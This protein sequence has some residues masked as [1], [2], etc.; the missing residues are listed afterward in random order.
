MCTPD[1]NRIGAL[2]ARWRRL[3]LSTLP[4]ALFL[5]AGCA[6][7]KARGLPEVEAPRKVEEVGQPKAEE[8]PK[9]ESPPQGQEA[10]TVRK[11]APPIEQEP[12]SFNDPPREYVTRE[13]GKWIVLVEKELVDEEP[14]LAERALAR[15]E[16]LLG[17]AFEAFPSSARAPL[18]RL[19]FFLMYGEKSKRGGRNNGLEYFQRT[20]PEHYKQLDSRMAS[21][22]LVYSATNWDWLPESRALKALVHELSH[23]Y[24]LEQWEELR[25]D[26]YDVWQNA[27]NLGLYRN[28]E[29]EDRKVLEQGYALQNHLEYF[30]ELS[31]IYFVGGYYKPFTREELQKYDPAGYALIRKIWQISD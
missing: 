1:T 7:E 13:M 17:K 19:R 29:D 10:P 24:H 9:A 20:A 14:D 8:P 16:K 30:A 2:T 3:L 18:D 12:V 22:V 11:T 28:V 26:I 5:A 21:S 23:A 27:K 4:L 25:P 6:S 15:F 31:A